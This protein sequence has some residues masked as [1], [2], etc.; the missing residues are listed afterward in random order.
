MKLTNQMRDAFVAS[1]ISDVPKI[2]YQTMF[3]DLA[4]KFGVE[5]LPS[6]VQAL[7]M[8]KPEYIAT[9]QIWVSNRGY[10]YVPGVD[11]RF[12]EAHKTQLEQIQLKREAQ[13]ESIKGL[14]TKLA[15]VVA[16]AWLSPRM[17][18]SAKSELLPLNEAPATTILPSAWIAM[19]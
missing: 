10:I 4:V 14:R 12:T 9:S 7:Y 2:D 19:L 18:I 1:V 5:M 11:V 15:G 17:R 8:R 6:D 16:G 13:E 3:S